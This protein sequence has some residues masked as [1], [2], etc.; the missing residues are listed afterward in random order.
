ML[1][2]LSKKPNMCLVYLYNLFWSFFAWSI[3]L[4][5]S[6][7]PVSYCSWRNSVFWIINSW[8]YEEKFRSEMTKVR[9]SDRRCDPG[10]ELWWPPGRFSSS[11]LHLWIMPVI[12]STNYNHKYCQFFCYTNTTVLIVIIITTEKIG[13]CQQG[14]ID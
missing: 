8:F 14:N 5:Y 6:E 1:Y 10:I 11:S 9:V 4:V 2:A 3:D 12:L 13:I 7:F